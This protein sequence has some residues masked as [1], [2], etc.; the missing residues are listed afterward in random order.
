MKEA[1]KIF[2][3]A[4][5]GFCLTPLLLEAVFHLLP[6]E[7][8]MGREPMARFGPTTGA[9]PG[10]A[11]SFARDWKFTQ[12]N[13][14]MINSDGFIGERDYPKT[15]A[16]EVV[17]VIGDSFVEAVM[18]PSADTLHAVIGDHL[19]R[20]ASGKVVGLGLSDAELATFQHFFERATEIWDLDFVVFVIGEG[21]LAD[22][23]VA[24]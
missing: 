3:I 10:R 9:S 20:G 15:G 17:A 22:A 8:G 18:T 12:L 13:R 6:V 21:D 23:F 5:L 1:M 14:G 19:T 24:Q 16:G 7:T 2:G 11:F 4:G